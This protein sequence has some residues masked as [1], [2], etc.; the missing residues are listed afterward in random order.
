MRIY[1]AIDEKESKMEN[2][3]AGIQ[4]VPMIPSKNSELIKSNK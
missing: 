3:K 1:K 4:S 2:K